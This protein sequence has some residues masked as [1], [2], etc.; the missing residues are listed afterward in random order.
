ML[1]KTGFSRT[2]SAD[3]SSWRF[4]MKN[5]THCVPREYDGSHLKFS[6]MNPEITLRPT[7]A[8]PLP[9]CCTAT[10]PAGA[11]VVGAG[12]TYEMVA[13]A[14]EKKRLGLCNKT[15]IA[16][17]NH[18]TGQFASEALCYIPMQTFW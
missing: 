10:T 17:P 14:M 1:L 7:S 13:A 18:L 6:G 11:H 9:I 4:T 12:K 5:L 3:K 2:V 16:V 15:L 8:M